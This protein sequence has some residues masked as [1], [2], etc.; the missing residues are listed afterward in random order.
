MSF[1][2]PLVLLALLVLPLLGIWY[3]AE[4]QRR[5]RTA[6]AFTSAKLTSS[7]A[8]CRPGWRD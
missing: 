7:V 6:L 2:T 3:A 8:P 4:Q 5:T 1:A